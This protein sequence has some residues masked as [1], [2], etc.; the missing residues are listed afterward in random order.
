MEERLQAKGNALAARISHR[1]GRSCDMGTALDGIRRA[2]KGRPGVKLTTLLHHIYAVDRLRAAYFRGERKGLPGWTGRR[3][4]RT[5]GTLKAN[6]W[7]CP[8]GSPEG[9]TGLS[10]SDACTSTKPA[11]ANARWACRRWRTS[12]SSLPRSKYSIRST[13]QWK[14]NR[15]LSG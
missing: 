5:D 9:L 6:F 15:R 8:T 10:L 13:T 1:L 12:L 7:T 3:G 4:S 2:A 14:L 11:A